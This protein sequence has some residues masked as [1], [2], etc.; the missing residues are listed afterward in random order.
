MGEE[1]IELTVLDIQEIRDDLVVFGT[2]FV[3]NQGPRFLTEL[4]DHTLIFDTNT[5]KLLSKM[6]MFDSAGWHQ[7]INLKIA[8][9]VRRTSIQ[10]VMD[11]GLREF[12]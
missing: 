9:K 2:Y 3:T 1:F 7:E 5:K 6:P 11:V 8:E 10:D 4:R 12:L